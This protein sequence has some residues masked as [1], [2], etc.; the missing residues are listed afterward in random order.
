MIFSHH[1]QLTITISIIAI[2]GE[3]E[4]SWCDLSSLYRRKTDWFLFLSFF[5]SILFCYYFRITEDPLLHGFWTRIRNFFVDDGNHSIWIVS[6]FA[7]F[8]RFIVYTLK[9]FSFFSITAPLLHFW[10]NNISVIHISANN[11]IYCKYHRNLIYLFPKTRCN[12]V[13]LIFNRRNYLLS[14][15]IYIFIY[16]LSSF[17]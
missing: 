1:K 8:I 9:S 5:L 12:Y 11:W 7:M 15:N 2:I 4:V 16:V 17:S 3:C 14:W 6:L 13:H 10:E